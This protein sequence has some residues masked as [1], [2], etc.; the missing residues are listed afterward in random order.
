MLQPIKAGFAKV[1]SARMLGRA[2]LLSVLA[3]LAVAAPAGAATI[4]ADLSANASYGGPCGPPYTFV[5][6]QSDAVTVPSSGTLTAW[7]FKNIDINDDTGQIVR[8]VVLHGN[9]AVAINSQTLPARPSTT[10]NLYQFNASVPV[11]GGVSASDSR[12]KI[13]TEC[14]AAR[15]SRPS[16]SIIGSRRSR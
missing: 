3:S 6:T 12:S 9:T 14:S 15:R 11:T 4:G 5:P 10:Q 7:R 2:A 1:A 13:S 16:C 8:L